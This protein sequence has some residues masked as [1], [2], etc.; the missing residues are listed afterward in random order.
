MTCLEDQIIC[1]ARE[2]GF[3][4]AGI[5]AVSASQTFNKYREW[6]AAG[7]SAG[8]G[9][10]EKR[11]ALRA[12][13]RNIMPEA[14]SV[15]VVA[16]RYPVNRKP[17]AGFSTYARGPDYHDVVRR[18][19]DELVKSVWPDMSPGSFRICVDSAP[20]LEREWA[21]RAGVG[22]RG[23]QG[24]I[25]NPAAGCCLVLGELFVNIELDADGPIEDRCG[26]CRRCVESCPTGALSESGLVDSR[27]CISY[28]TIE[29]K[30]DVAPEARRSLG[31]AIFGCDICTAVCPWNQ[32]GDNLV[33]P[34]LRERD[35]PSAGAIL[36]MNEEDFEKRFKGTAV[37]RTGLD[38]LK[39]N[40]QIAGENSKAS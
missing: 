4:A 2:L 36:G 6:L 1:K 39:R 20:V 17:G 22:W 27:K 25:V 24:Q 9:Y 33:M 23:R 29:H 10:L 13:P 16:A 34:E 19:L 18:K 35:A 15:V 28:L 31:G 40:A 11:A 21:V 37:F 5:A 26:D 3:A 7:M 14:R 30:G 8:M 12:D 38:R 32:Y